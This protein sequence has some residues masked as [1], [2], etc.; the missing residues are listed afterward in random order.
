MKVGW[1]VSGG[2]GRLF[3]DGLG[4]VHDVLADGGEGDV[5]VDEAEGVVVEGGGVEDV[6]EQ[7]AQPLPRLLHRLQPLPHRP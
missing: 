1:G 4:E 3:E 7:V 6:V 2:G 5:L